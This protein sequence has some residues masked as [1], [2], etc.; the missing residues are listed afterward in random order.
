MG[1]QAAFSAF[2]K[3]PAHVQTVSGNIIARCDDLVNQ[4]VFHRFLRRHEIVAVGITRHFFNA[5]ARVVGQNLVQLFFQF[6]Q[7]ARM[8]FN[9][10]RLAAQSAANQSLVNHNAAV[11]QRE[12]FAFGAGRQ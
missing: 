7:F 12:T 10:G 4:A 9:V 1:V 3:Q 11:R 8:N 2:E 6:Q 5:F